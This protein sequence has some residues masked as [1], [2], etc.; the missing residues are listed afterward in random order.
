MLQRVL[1]YVISFL[2]IMAC[3]LVGL[4][5]QHLLGLAIPAA[6]LEC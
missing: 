1:G 5:I 2:V 6:Y 4:T 3:L